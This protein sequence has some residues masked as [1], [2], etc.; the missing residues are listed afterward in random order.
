MSSGQV[1]GLSD[2]GLGHSEACRVPFVSFPCVQV[3]EVIGELRPS[4]V[5]QDG[6]KTDC[7]P[8]RKCRHVRQG[9]ARASGLIKL[10]QHP[11]NC[12]VPTH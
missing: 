7:D 9:T 10:K 11:I 8:S 1:P 4:L 3:S 6:R 2:I 12:I 5:L